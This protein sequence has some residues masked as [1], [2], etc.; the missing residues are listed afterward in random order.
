[1]A[2]M[3]PALF[4]CPEDSKRQAEKKVYDILRDRLKDEYTVFYSFEILRENRDGK[5]AESE[6]DFLIFHP[7]RG[8]IG[9]EVKGGN[10]AY[11]DGCWSQNGRPLRRS[12]FAQAHDAIHDLERWLASSP[13]CL[14]ST[15]NAPW[16]LA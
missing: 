16:C 9:L 1:M 4:P 11:R 10:I 13:S 2:Q 8:F 5:F 12:P 6:T 14:A 7:D 15:S 3:I